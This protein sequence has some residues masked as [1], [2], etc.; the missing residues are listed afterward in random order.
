MKERFINLSKS[1]KAV[2]TTGPKTGKKHT[3][4]SRCSMILRSDQGYTVSTIAELEDTTRQTIAR[5]FNRYEDHGIDGLHT[6][7]GRARPPIVR[8][9]NKNMIN[10][11]EKLVEEYPQN[12]DQAL[13]KIEEFTGQSMSR[14]T[15]QRVLKK[16]VGLGNAS[17]DNQQ[18]GPQR[19]K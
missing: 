14:K 9:D 11:I 5:W 17:A 18:S 16:T 6:G 1:E 2:L 12:L 10:K 3:F 15:L 7:K 8:I 4:R 19:K 13:I